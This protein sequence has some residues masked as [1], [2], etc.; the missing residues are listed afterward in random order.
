MVSQNE[1]MNIMNSVLN[2]IL[3]VVLTVFRAFF[4][5]P[6]ILDSRKFSRLGRGE[7]HSPG[8]KLL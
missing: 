4:I 7:K 6:H 3:R 5:A 1:M 2:S 8:K